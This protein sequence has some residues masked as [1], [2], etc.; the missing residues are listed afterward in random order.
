LMSKDKVLSGKDNCTFLISVSEHNGDEG[1]IK[2]T[3]DKKR[4]ITIFLI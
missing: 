4:I 3:S 2:N 1:F